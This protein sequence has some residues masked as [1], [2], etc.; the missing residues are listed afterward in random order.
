MDKRHEGLAPV[1]YP[2]QERGALNLALCGALGTRCK[3]ESS[4]SMVPVCSLNGALDR[5]SPMSHVDFKKCQYRMS[6]L[7]IFHNGTEKTLLHVNIFLPIYYLS[8]SPMSHVEL[9]KC[10]CHPV[11][12]RGQEP[13]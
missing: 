8:Q 9:K 7:L 4:R 5:R 13:Y 12:F 3:T 2:L 11:D 1:L 6:L 10:P